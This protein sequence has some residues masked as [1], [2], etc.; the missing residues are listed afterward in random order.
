MAS[1]S[2]EIRSE[3]FGSAPCWIQLQNFCVLIGELLDL[4]TREEQI[5][6]LDLRNQMVHSYFANRHRE[7]VVVKYAVRGKLQTEK[8][9]DSDYHAIVR[10]FHETGKSVDAVLAPMI[11]RALDQKLRYWTAIGAMQK[12]RDA[13]YKV[14]IEG[15]TFEIK[16]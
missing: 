1:R 9:S 4:F 8:L 13:I 11:A 15:K 12:E 16:V 7:H 10:S 2:C 3:R 14:L 6:L 5:Y